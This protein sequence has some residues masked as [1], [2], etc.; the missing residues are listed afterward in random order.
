VAVRRI[1]V[2]Q[3]KC[4]C[5]DEGWRAAWLRGEKPPTL[6]FGP[7]GAESVH[8]ALFHKIAEDFV[9]WLSA[10]A[11]LSAA[12]SLAGEEDLWHALYDRF[13][14]KRLGKLAATGELRSAHRLSRCLRA[15]SRRLEGL[16]RRTPNFST[17]RD[18]YL[19]QEFPLRAVRLN[20]TAKDALLVSGQVDA[21]RSHPRFGLELVD[22]K[23]SHGSQAKH[24]LVQLA[25]YARLLAVAK[26]GLRFAG[27]L[28][29]YEPELQELQAS[30]DELEGIFDEVVAPLLPDLT[31]GNR[32]AAPQRPSSP[33]FVARADAEP[34]T[35][36]PDL[37][38]AIC[39][40][41]A[42]FNLEVEV[43]DR[44]EAPQ[45]VR[46]RV[47]PA[48]GV[49]VVSLVNRAQDLQVALSL[50]Q[51]PLIEPAQGYVSIDIPKE[52][53]DT[54][55]WSDAIRRAQDRLA[56]SPV[57]FPLG[58]GVDGEVLV[59][60]F[61]DPN[62]AHALVGGASGSGKSEFLKAVAASLIT[63]NSPE[64]LRLTIIDPKILTFGALSGM[65]HLSGP[66]ITDLKEAVACLQRLVGDMDHRYRELAAEGY[67]N[68]SQRHAAGGLGLPFH[69]LI[70]DEFADLV[71]AGKKEKQ[72]FES[73]VARLAGK[74]RAAGIHLVL[75]TQ[76]PDRNI[77]TGPIKANLPL[78]VCLRVT[79]ATNS[80]IV[81]DQG[82]GE[83]LVGRG[84]LLCDRGKG[85]ERAQSPWVTP[86]DF[87]S[88]SAVL[89]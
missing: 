26:P 32:R 50:V 56:A 5:L 75:A 40:C 44:R 49:K 46:Y 48:A 72:T 31:G 77:V 51:P 24:D 63:R 66:V 38:Q 35:P 41:F 2:S 6:S 1:T 87:A 30:F 45:L 83:A 37:S 15:F 23:L 84:D 11:S 22:Y 53:P 79:S 19:D 42:S 4:A 82:G 86:E 10:D 67:E 85:V 28:E 47:R 62:T 61:S 65:P 52:R 34:A 39:Q 64:T 20:V 21:L 33:T 58:V 78:K 76:R 8:G 25:I 9:A 36:A 18:V 29:Y 54:V 43:L 68:L 55:L 7:N 89:A 81:L 70:F 13:A 3:L 14:G 80:Q 73:L 59:A 57:A 69:V 71:L 88:L 27:T 17:W 12:A 74:G 16:R 60:D